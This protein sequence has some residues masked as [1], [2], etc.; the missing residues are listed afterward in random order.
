MKHIFRRKGLAAVALLVV[1]G[2]I[3]WRPAAAQQTSILSEV[4]KRGTIRVGVIGGN[5]PYSKL[6]PSGEPEGYD[7]DIAKA[8]AASLKVKPEWV[9]VDVPG[10]IVSL[11]T[12]KADITIADFTKTVERSTTIAFT[13]PYLVVG[14][15][16]LVLANRDDLKTVD[17]LNDPKQK[18]GI[19]RS[20]T[21][22]QNVPAALPKAPLARFDNLADIYQALKTKQVDAMSQDNLYNAE[23]IAKSPGQFKNIPGLYSREEIAIGLPLGDF[24]WW[25][26]MNTWV[27]QFNASGENAK[28]FKKWFGYDLPP[29]LTNY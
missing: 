27:E 1:L 10:R 3:G 15:Q 8:I 11:Q 18:I 26:V 24:D 6:S 20:G 19:T 17:D 12:H 14:L 4:V 7:I 2:A 9:I 5:P 13:D 29:I 21:A 22:E 23:Q 28:L 16:F 25:R